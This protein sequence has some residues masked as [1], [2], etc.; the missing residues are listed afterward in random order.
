MLLQDVIC[1]LDWSPAKGSH[2]GFSLGQV[3]FKIPAVVI[4]DMVLRL[5]SSMENTEEGGKISYVSPRCSLFLRQK[6]ALMHREP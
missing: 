6:F 2:T 3:D 1:N 4:E 5:Y